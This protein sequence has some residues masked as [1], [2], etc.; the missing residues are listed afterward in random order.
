[1]DGRIKLLLLEDSEMD[2]DLLVRHLHKEKIDFKYVRV[3]KKSTFQ[4]QLKLFAPDIIIADYSLSQFTGVEAFRLMKQEG[5]N[6]PFIL[7]SGSISEKIILQI[8]KEGIDDYLLKDNLNRLS[9]MIMNVVYKKQLEIEKNRVEIEKKL[10]EQKNKDILDSINYAKRIQ[11][12]IFPPEEL[13]KEL[14]PESF[15]LL[16]PKDIIS[17]DFYWVEKFDKKTFIGAV[18]C[19]GHGVPGALLSIVGYNLLSKA[20]NEHNHTSPDEILNEL[21]NGINKTLRQN[22]ESSNVNDTMDVALCSI[23]KITNTLEFAGAYNSLYLIRN[24]RLVEIHADRFPVGVFL[25]GQLRKFTNHKL[26]LEKGDTIYLFSDGY[27]DQFGGEKG[28]KFKHKQF[29]KLLISI[30][31]LSIEEQK[32]RL[33]STIEEWQSMTSEEQTDDILVIGIKYNSLS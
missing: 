6:L 7:A 20:I 28:K 12:A 23:D 2:A 8:I 25:N 9:N 16:K 29:K 31:D 19:T 22:I 21:S 24:K 5:Y 14:L 33:N 4:E 17:G 32:N 10:V 13:V 18:D 27:A 1:M 3:W 30:Q 26:Q 11:D 15:I